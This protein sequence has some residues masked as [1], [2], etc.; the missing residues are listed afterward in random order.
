MDHQR[1]YIYAMDGYPD[2][3]WQARLRLVVQKARPRV[4]RQLVHTV[5]EE[6]HT[7]SEYERKF[8]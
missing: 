3:I 4:I 6:A 2:E 5:A 8:A 7:E 1:F